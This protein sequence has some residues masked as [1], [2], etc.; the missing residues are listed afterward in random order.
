MISFYMVYT[1]HENDNLVCEWCISSTDKVTNVYQIIKSTMVQY[2]YILYIQYIHYMYVYI[3]CCSSTP[4]LRL[5]CTTAVKGL[6]RGYT[7]QPEE[8]TGVLLIFTRFIIL[9][10]NI[11]NTNSSNLTSLI[12][13]N[14]NIRSSIFFKVLTINWST[15]SILKN[16]YHFELNRKYHFPWRHVA[17]NTDSGYLPIWWCSISIQ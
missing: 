8:L 10:I 13:I 9:K 15:I 4:F 17:C 1:I 2:V 12:R 16:V 3:W 6:L 14:L 11:E 7:S 5:L